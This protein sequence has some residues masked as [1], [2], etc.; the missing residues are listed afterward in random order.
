MSEAVLL[1]GTKKG[2]W[3]GRSDENVRNGNGRS[4]NF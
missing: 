2:L 1:V 4:R 3:V